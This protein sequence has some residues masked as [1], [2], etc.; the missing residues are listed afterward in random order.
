MQFVS[1]RSPL[2]DVLYR[3]YESSR[4]ES[5]REC[6]GTNSLPGL[7]F[8]LL[9]FALLCSALP[10][11]ARI[12]RTGQRKVVS[13]EAPL[14]Y[15]KR[16]NKTKR[17]TRH[18]PCQSFSYSHPPPPRLPTAAVSSLG[19]PAPVWCNNVRGGRHEGHSLDG[20]RSH[21]GTREGDREGGGRREEGKGK[22]QGQ[23]QGQGQA[24]RVIFLQ[25]ASPRIF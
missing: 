17:D 5:S 13:S 7:C 23:G 11:L 21:G 12:I 15:P 18:S 2:F 25:R 14:Y 3:T 1:F 9:C 4:V 6:G 22:V 24:G 8:D 16:K 10:L 20:S 19:L